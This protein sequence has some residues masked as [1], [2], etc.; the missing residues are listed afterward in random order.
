METEG[1]VTEHN[2]GTVATVAITKDDST[3]SEEIP[4]SEETKIKLVS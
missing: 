3:N 2:E 1:V 4:I